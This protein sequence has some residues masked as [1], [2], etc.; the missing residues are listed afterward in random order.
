MLILKAV[1]SDLT[2]HGGFQWPASGPVECPDWLPT[3]TCGRG[4]HGWA[5]GEGDYVHEGSH[6]LVFDSLD[7]Q[8][9]SLASKVKTG[10]RAAVVFSGSQSDAV[11]YLIAAGALTPASNPGWCCFSAA[12]CAQLAAMC[13]E[14]AKG[15]AAYAAAT[16][17][18][19]TDR[20]ASA[21]YAAS[22]AR[23]TS[24]AAYA[25]AAT[26]RAATSWASAS[27]AAYAASWAAVAATSHAA[28]A[29]AANAAAAAATNAA[30]SASAA[31]DAE[32]EAQRQDKLRMLGL[33]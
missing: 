9:I 20:A 4:L 7:S 6:W 30:A 13:S 16:D 23:A 3:N 14:R 12:Q 22:A 18:A 10:P 2:A 26:D 11:K 1:K 15:Y 33:A 5:N 17:K 8:V 19:A 24:H 21:A 25:A 31:A 32:R 28:T 27:A 29:D